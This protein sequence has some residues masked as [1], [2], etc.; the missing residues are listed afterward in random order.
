MEDLSKHQLILVALLVSFVTSLATGIFTVSLMSQAPQGVVQTINQAVEKLVTPQ[1]ASVNA[2]PTINPEEKVTNAVSKVSK[3]IV[4]FHG[5]DSKTIVGLGLVISKEG[6]V[7]VDKSTLAQIIGFQ[8]VFA[9]GVELPM[10][11][12]QS[13]TNGDIVF[14]TPSLSASTTF[15]PISFGN[16]SKLGQTVLT[17]SGLSS[18]VLS[19]GIISRTLLDNINPDGSQPAIIDTNISKPDMTLGSPLFNVEGEVIGISTQT[20]SRGSDAA[21]FYP[22][23]Q[24]KSVIPKMR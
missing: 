12:I 17:L 10:T 23:A 7:I 11:I 3:S 13:Q 20:V 1:K 15:N 8:A 24:L 6:I 4:K 21:S 19:Q 18:P 14:L 2:S 16:S 22:I 5:S 9:N